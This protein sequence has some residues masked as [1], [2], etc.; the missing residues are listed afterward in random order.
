M[1]VFAG[2]LFQRTPE[3]LSH[4]LNVSMPFEEAKVSNE[5][6]MGGAKLHFG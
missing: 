3:E 1:P 6:K 2:W 4:K 5:I